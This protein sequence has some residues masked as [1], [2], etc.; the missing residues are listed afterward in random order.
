MLAFLYYHLFPHLVFGTRDS[1]AV[2][3]QRIL[4]SLVT[5]ALDGAEQ[6]VHASTHMLNDCELYSAKKQQHSVSILILAQLNR[7]ILWNLASHGSGTNNLDLAQLE[8]ADWA[9]QFAKDEHGIADAGFNGMLHSQ[10][11]A[12]QLETLILYNVVVL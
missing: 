9:H 3:A 2:Y 6:P 8:L 11:Q 4:G 1:H 7:L 5:Y 10:R 12:L